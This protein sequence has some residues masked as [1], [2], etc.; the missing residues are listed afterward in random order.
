MVP[1]SWVKAA[2]VSMGPASPR[3]SGLC[4]RDSL[5]TQGEQPPP[6]AIVGSEA[7]R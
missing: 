6:Q 1:D 5:S 3:G 4:P 7:I 2:R